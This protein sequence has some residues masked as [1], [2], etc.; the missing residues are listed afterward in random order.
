M[1]DLASL[2]PLAPR[3]GRIGLGCVTFGREIDAD[4]A[5]AVMDHAVARGVTHFDTAAAYGAGA[6]ER[7]VGAWLAS[8]RPAQ[9]PVIATK[10]LP[11]YSPAAMA[12]AV[13][14]SRERL[15]VDAIDLLYVHKWSDELLAPETL[16]ALDE[17]VR[18]GEVRALGASNIT[19]GQ[20]RR[21][22]D[23][24]RRHGG[25][26]LSALQ[27]N[28]NYAVRDVDDA[29]RAICT[30]E[31]IAL[32]TYSPLGAGFLTGKHK[33]G[34]APGSRFE[35]IPGHQRIY[36]TPQGWQR[37]ARLETVAQHSGLPLPTL[38]LAW[39]FNQAGPATVLVGGRTTAQIDQAFAA[40]ALGRPRWLDELADG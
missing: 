37:L 16:A 15:G 23:L 24:Q 32:V 33:A 2:P 17:V 31:S 20:L 11:P 9:P 34:V 40:L 5:F 8:R 36:F 13:A 28:H 18:R 4:Q 27:N 6:S 12:K 1:A 19:A 3:L 26:R 21:L 22:L 39:A 29:V 25:V 14:E 38:A 30:P 7:V 35:V 10:I